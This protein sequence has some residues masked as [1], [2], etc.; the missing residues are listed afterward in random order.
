MKSMIMGQLIAYNTFALN[1]SDCLA[2][3]FTEG[4]PLGGTT[5]TYSGGLLVLGKSVP[6]NS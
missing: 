2:K 1:P 5:I 3:T 6:T 4:G